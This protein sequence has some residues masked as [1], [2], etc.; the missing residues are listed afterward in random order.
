VSA[1]ISAS[2][3][4]LH[5]WQYP[6]ELWYLGEEEMD[7]KLSMAFSSLGVTCVNTKQFLSGSPMR[8]FGGWESKIFSVLQS[9]LEEILFLDADCVPVANPAPLFSLNDYGH[10]G[11]IF[12]P[13]LERHRHDSNQ[14]RWPVF[15]VPYRDVPEWET[16][17]FLV[18]KA[19]CWKSLLLSHF[20]NS[21]SD[22]YYQFVRGDKDC[23]HMAWLK[24]GQPFSLMPDTEAREWGLR[25]YGPSGGL[26]FQHR[27]LA[28]FRFA[29]PQ[30]YPDFENEERC[31]SHIERLRSL[32]PGF[33]P[34]WK[35]QREE[36]TISVKKLAG[37]YLYAP[38]GG[39]P[40]TLTLLPDG[41]VEP[42]EQIPWT[43]WRPSIR[44]ANHDI[45][46]QSEDGWN[47]LASAA[48]DYYA[49]HW[50]MEWDTPFLLFRRS[51]PQSSP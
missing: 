25:Q 22:Y 6:I 41:S 30:R 20:Y 18:N 51:K 3:L 50:P 35:S 43:A 7:G 49:G 19:Q 38:S 29:N 8:C 1:Y 26:L 4:R 13:D 12:W 42:G 14:A 17:Q 23:C 36:D 40:Q 16:G 39:L 28:K 47:C 9:R 48:G 10:T 21:N 45:T 46:L 44:S 33:D 2:E 34:A 31:L 24:T 11:A 27:T 15:G 32:W 5:G 37:E